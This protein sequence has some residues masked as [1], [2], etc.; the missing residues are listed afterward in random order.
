LT[1]S[2]RVADAVCFVGLALS[3]TVK[4]IE[5]VPMVAVVLVVPLIFPVVRLSVSP[6]GSAT[7]DFHL[8]A[9][10][11]PSLVSVAE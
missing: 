9:P 6:F 7:L 1:W 3:V 2:L 4:T 8:T 10:T 5:N 11:P